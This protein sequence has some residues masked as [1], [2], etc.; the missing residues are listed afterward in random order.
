MSK[1]VERSIDWAEADRLKPEINKAQKHSVPSAIWPQPNLQKPILIL[2][3]CLA[4]SGCGFHL[5]GNLDLPSWLNN[6]AVVLE[7]A[8]RDLA[9]NIVES[10]KSYD[11]NVPTDPGLA[12]YWLI[13][14][15]DNLQQNISSVS[16]ST[17]SRQYEL[18]YSVRFKLVKAHGKEMIPSTTIAITRQTTVNNNR[19]LGSNQEE[20]LLLHEM[21]RDA[22]TQIMNRVSRYHAH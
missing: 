10:L 13:I 7:N 1:M 14:E 15:Q 19:I 16:S 11:I 4:L 12:Q 2:F 8:H 6:I 22:A 21:R 5:R 9:H 17:T 18:T 3:L 20:E